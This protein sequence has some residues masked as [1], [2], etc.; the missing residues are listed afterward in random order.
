M[1]EYRKNKHLYDRCGVRVRAVITTSLQEAGVRYQYS[2]DRVKEADSLKEKLKKKLE[3]ADLNKVEKIDDVIRDTLGLRVIVYLEKDIDRV[4]GILREEFRIHDEKPKYSER[5][6][7]HHLIAQINDKRSDLP[8][9]NEVKDII[10]EI[11]IT[12]VLYYGWNELNHDTFYKP[13]AGVKEFHPALFDKV[14]NNFA[15]IVKEYLKPAQD[16]FEHNLDQ[17]QR[18]KEGKEVFSAE[19]LNSL[20]ESKSNNEIQ[21]R[22]QWLLRNI[23]Y[24]GDR[25]PE[26]LNIVKVIDTVLE[27]LET[28]PQDKSE[29]T[30]IGTIPGATYTDNV[31][32]C[33][34]I[35][36][37]IRFRYPVEIFEILCRLFFNGDDKVKDKVLKIATNMSKY[38]FIEQEKRIYYDT[39]YM[40][41]EKIIGWSDDKQ[42]DY[43]DLIMK[44]CG[45]VV[46]TRFT[47]SAMIKYDILSIKQ[48]DIPQ[49]QVVQEMI[50]R[51]ICILER[52]YGNAETFNQK[53]Y[54]LITLRNALSSIRRYIDTEQGAQVENFNTIIDFYSGV[55][56]NTTAHDYEIIH[57]IEEQVFQMKGNL[58]QNADDKKIEHLQSLIDKNREYQIY[59]DFANISV[60][61]EQRNSENFQKERQTRIEEY[62]QQIKL[63][64]NDKWYSRIVSMIIS[65][66]SHSDPGT[67]NDLGQHLIEIGRQRSDLIHK[68]LI[69]YNQ[70]ERVKWYIHFLLAG[71]W[72]SN[73][74]Q[75]KQLIEAWVKQGKHLYFCARMFDNADTTDNTLL[76]KIYKKAIEQKDTKTL[77]R[78]V[79]ASIKCFEKEKK[80]KTLLLNCISKLGD[81]RDYQWIQFYSFELKEGK[82]LKSFTPQ[83]W[84]KFLKGCLYVNDDMEGIESIES[85]L[86]QSTP[87]KIV[88][89]FAQR[90]AIAQKRNK[91]NPPLQP[92]FSPIPYSF[93]ELGGF[94]SKHSE[95]TV[96]E[97]FKWFDKK[98]M[99][100]HDYTYNFIRGIFPTLNKDIETQLLKL[101]KSKNNHKV[102]IAIQLLFWYGGDAS[103]HNVCKAFIKQYPDHK[104]DMF[105]VL[106][107]AASRTLMGEYG[108]VKHYKQKKEEVEGWKKD[109][110]KRIRDFVKEYQGYL[111][112]LITQE[113]RKVER[114]I[115]RRKRE[116]GE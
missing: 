13:E 90:I 112:K 30:I 92:Y 38:V 83:E 111:D 79:G 46:L 72:N 105:A 4:V 63:S 58:K 32:I 100:Y 44:V 54:I 73:N 78:V 94:L 37:E 52:M 103:I 93:N 43:F 98:N 116:F 1:Q 102:K 42:K 110:D 9:Y 39:Q 24:F 109:K 55:V 29:Q 104:Q 101:I 68:I 14:E 91:K 67:Y 108:E 82:I 11:Q 89:F 12:T 25:A 56:E 95:I 69:E 84:N 45:E 53:F 28:L 71:V 51:A 86:I 75:A 22:L 65:N 18:I 3:D 87:E 74:K 41:L 34:D 107:S 31:L 57:S 5:Y 17:L 113:T 49:N 76:N 15:Q 16:D 8:E 66:N 2:S 21:K 85:I 106:S 60:D 19:S 35:L 36:N 7:A 20:Q 96:R 10:F 40:I 26:K 115:A 80:C 70:D 59:K 23:Q 50:A 62:I 97:I 114:D 47:N 48:G 27:N 64:K 33:L 99:P 6:N 61:W 88:D 81:Y 77:T